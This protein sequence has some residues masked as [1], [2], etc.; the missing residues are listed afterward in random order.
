MCTTKVLLVAFIGFWFDRS[1]DNAFGRVSFLEKK[2]A[3]EMLQS[4]DKKA[5]LNIDT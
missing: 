2:K 4:I 1:R 3:D 5:R